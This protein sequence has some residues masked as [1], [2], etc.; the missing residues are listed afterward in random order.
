MSNKGKNATV[1]IKLEAE[2]GYKAEVEAKI[3]PEQWGEIMK[4]I[5]SKD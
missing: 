5:E 1:K 3:S 4:I 2:S